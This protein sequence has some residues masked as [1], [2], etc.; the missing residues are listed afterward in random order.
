LFLRSSR[1]DHF[2]LTTPCSQSMATSYKTQEFK[3]SPRVSAE[4]FDI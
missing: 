4:S 3:S 1:G 2:P